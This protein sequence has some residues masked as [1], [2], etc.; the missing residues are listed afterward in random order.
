MALPSSGQI[1][2]DEMHVEAGGSTG[3]LATINDSDIRGL[4]GKSAGVQMAFDEWYGASARV[5]VNLTLSS[6][7]N[8]YN[9]YFNRG[10]SYSA[11]K[12]DVTLTINSGVTVGST[13]TGAYAL[14][15][16][17]GWTS[18][19]T[20]SITNSGTIKGRGGNG[21]NGGNTQYN[22]SAGNGTA[23]GTGGPA[24]RAQ[25][26][27]SFTNNGS[28]Y[29]GGGGGGGGG[30]YWQQVT[31]FKSTTYESYGGG[32][33]GGGAGVNGGTGGS[34]GTATTSSGFSAVLYPGAAGSAGTATAG[35][36]GGGTGSGAGGAGGGLGANGSNGANGSTAQA[37]S[38]AGTGGSG[39][40]RGY[41]QV[42]S[43]LINSGSGIGGT[44]GGRSL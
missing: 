27:C 32:G 7:T 25:Y 30:G 42:G 36:A 35:G 39:G 10:G 2:L 33:G 8:N 17:S 19:D 9:I 22:V 38:S 12:T 3:T 1:T 28:V 44:V 6:N 13:S 24:F 29:G 23:G 41:Y 37:I 15:T 20:I 5:T 31:V 40:T 34:G 18:G 16:G 14:D 11:G 4:I 26:A 21:G 43:S